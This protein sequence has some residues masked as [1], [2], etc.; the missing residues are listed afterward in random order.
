MNW[1][2][3]KIST[4]T[5]RKFPF[6]LHGMSSKIFRGKIRQI[7][8]YP[9][10]QFSTDR[11]Q[12]VFLCRN[13][14]HIEYLHFAKQ[15]VHCTLQCV[16]CNPRQ[17]LVTST[18][19]TLNFFESCTTKVLCCAVQPKT[20]RLCGS[21]TVIILCL[22]GSFTASLAKHP[23]PGDSCCPHNPRDYWHSPVTLL[24]GDYGMVRGV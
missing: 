15:C 13:I 16:L 21:I 1:K 12:I 19:S 11:M 3:F 6:L 10:D 22:R 24:L 14:A 17:Y 7:K 9:G 18:I 23:G 4:S 8:F 5:R 20:T 2:S